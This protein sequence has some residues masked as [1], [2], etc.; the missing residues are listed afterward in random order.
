MSLFISHVLDMHQYEYREQNV[1]YLAENTSDSLAFVRSDMSL[2]EYFMDFLEPALAF[3]DLFFTIKCHAE[4]F[5]AFGFLQKTH[6]CTGEGGV[7]TVA[8]MRPICCLYQK[9]NAFHINNKKTTL[10][11]FVSKHL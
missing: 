6:T 8:I 2:E 1:D 4:A 10:L 7:V 5:S 9:V 11:I 3:L